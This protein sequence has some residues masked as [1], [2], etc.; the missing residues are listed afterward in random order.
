MIPHRDFENDDITNYDY[1]VNYDAQNDGLASSIGTE[2]QR[3]R[4][5]FAAS[6]TIFQIYY[7]SHQRAILSCFEIYGETQVNDIRWW[8]H[9]CEAVKNRSSQWNE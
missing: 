4:E 7:S 9:H 2:S 1:Q 5:V 8:I 6:P 3:D